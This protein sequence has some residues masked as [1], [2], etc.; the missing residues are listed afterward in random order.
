[1]TVVRRLRPAPDPRSAA[2]RDR[3][4]RMNPSLSSRP[5]T[6][7]PRPTGA[8]FAAVAGIVVG[9]ALLISMVAVPSP[10]ASGVPTQ[11]AA[12]ET[13]TAIAESSADPTSDAGDESPTASHSG[14]ADASPGNSSTDEP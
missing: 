5:S 10:Q 6:P 9:S 8:M 7:S 1:M 14:A 11:E 4:P 2:Y 13:F 3:S 12:P